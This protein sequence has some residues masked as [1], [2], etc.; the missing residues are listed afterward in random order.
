MTTTSATRSSLRLDVDGGGGAV[1]SQSPWLPGSTPSPAFIGCPCSGCQGIAERW[2]TDKA[3]RG[4]EAAATPGAAA[5][6]AGILSRRIGRR[7]GRRPATEQARRSA[8]LPFLT[9]DR[10]RAV[11][12]MEDLVPAME[13][14]LAEFS[15]GRVSKPPRQMLTVEPHGGYFGAMPA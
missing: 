3:L 10:V 8:M 13:G 9:E 5:E 11:L 1:R 14:A 2:E 6:R 4:L 7:A 12:R 15:A